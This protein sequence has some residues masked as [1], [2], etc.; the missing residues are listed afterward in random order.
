MKR[1]IVVMFF[2]LCLIICFMPTVS[3][4][5]TNVIYVSSSGSDSTG[6]GS[7]GNPYATLPKACSVAADGSTVRVMTDLTA[8]SLTRVTD[9]HLTI[10]S[11]DPA[12]PVTISRGD[13]FNTASDVARPSYNPAMFEV[14]TNP[15][16]DHENASS[17]RFEN[18]V[19]DDIGKHVN[20]SARQ[21]GIVSA[22]GLANRQVSLIIG[23]GTVLRNY[24]GETAIFCKSLVNL[25]I[26]SGS[27]I[28]DTLDS[29]ILG[30]RGHGCVY[31][32]TSKLDMQSGAIIRNIVNSTR[33]VN[34]E[35]SKDIKIDGEISGLSGK[36]NIP[37]RFWG[38][39]GSIGPNGHIH[40][41]QCEFGSLYGRNNA[42]VTIYGKITDNSAHP[43]VAKATGG[44]FYF[45]SHVTLEPGSEICNNT[46]KYYAGGVDLQETNSS[47]TMNGGK[48][49]NNTGYSYFFSASIGGIQV[50]KS[51]A[52]F[53]MNG[54]EIS[55]NQGDYG[56]FL[57][58]DNPTA[59]LNDGVINDK[60]GFASSIK[61]G[62][63]YYGNLFSIG[64]KSVHAPL[65]GKIQIHDSSKDIKIGK[66]SDGS[67]TVLKNFALAN[68]YQA[69]LS[70]FWIHKHKPAKVSIKPAFAALPD[71]S[72]MYALVNETDNMGNPLPGAPVYTYLANVNNGQADFT[73]PNV[74]PNGCAVAICKS[75]GEYGSLLLETKK[76]KISEKKGAANYKIPYTLTYKLTPAAKSVLDNHG[77]N[78]A[79]LI[80]YSPLK[81]NDASGAYN[82]TGP[83]KIHSYD[84]V[85]KTLDLNGYD[86]TLDTMI[87][88]G[89][90][91]LDAGN[92]VV[93]DSIHTSAVLAI[94]T[95]GGGPTIYIPSN[96]VE[97]L[98][99]AASKP[100]LT[101]P[102]AP[103]EVKADKY[104]LH[105]DSNGGTAYA[106]EEF[107]DGTIV[108]LNKHP[109]REG[110]TFTGW[111]S[112]KELKNK[113]E[114]V[115]MD[116]DK[117]VY[118]GW[119][120]S[121]IPKALNAEEHFAYI[122]GLPDGL[123]HPNKN[124]SRAEIATI[125]YRLLKE[126]VRNQN[127]SRE[128]TFTDVTPNLWFNTA[129]ST[130][131]K[132]DIFKGRSPKRFDPNTPITRGEFAALCARFNN[133]TEVNI[134]NLKD[135][136]GH[137]AE[138][139]IK[140]VEA[141]GWILGDS[142]N[143]FLPDNYITRAE[144]V[145]II[146]RIL[147]RIPENAESL[148]PGM[149]LWSDNPPSAWYYIAIQEA[150]NSHEFTRT[151]GFHEKWTKLLP[152]LVFPM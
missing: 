122:I 9:K 147:Q 83:F 20:P 39:S 58:N 13:G 1:K 104:V 65:E 50:R 60:V 77:I 42:S 135:I 75:T 137:W 110:H 32:H 141:L 126:D 59:I 114:N 108:T 146:N 26:E 56:V 68:G 94:T 144:A 41:N 55:G 123:V 16:A 99:T 57:N 140:S 93:G 143:M 46:G 118:A 85:S 63:V 134:D 86:N 76:N 37:V 73:V 80:F 150:T 120:V 38:S 132:L 35:Y 128:N 66:A 47:L 7:Q 43:A 121:I 67:K 129:I 139:E 138:K 100:G 103:P 112:D 107:K 82:I 5:G 95:N 136:K 131:V 105:Y 40:H 91:I 79:K 102:P 25:T 151:D 3:L 30:N 4:A 119:E 10:T 148:L 117:T 74:F 54:G 34:C 61:N 87:L 101:G 36:S 133:P 11:D 109:D 22:Y 124:I 18:I 69:P 116:K 8:T 62:F 106:D 96:S 45:G 90:G 52:K 130:L 70:R 29:T 89:T 142:N 48:I 84:S 15:G 53:I 19:L 31:I 28:E 125:L 27:I 97:T 49:C 145:T 64:D 92:F 111:Y 21:D 33:G 12:N 152:N 113:I 24:G 127:L 2:S 78:T 72:I 14:T 17:I 88:K 51:N 71:G 44:L 81:A 6:D 149:K 115:T 98:M 23:P